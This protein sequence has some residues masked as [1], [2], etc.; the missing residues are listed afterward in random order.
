MAN[1]I[2]GVVGAGI[3][4]QGIVQVACL[5]PTVDKV[6]WKSAYSSDINKVKAKLAA[7]F[8]KLVEKDKFSDAQARD[9]LAKIYVSTD[10]KDFS[11][12]HIL[13][14]VVSEDIQI[15]AS[16]IS[17]LGKFLGK[18]VIIASNT[19]SLS[20]TELATFFS[21]PDRFI[22]MHF[23]NPAGL[24]QLVEI[25]SGVSTSEETKLF[26]SE[27]AN[28][29]D[30]V[31]VHVEE[32]PGFIVNRIL[33][34]MINEAIAILAESI[35]DRDSIDLAMKLGANHPIGPL[36]LS[37]LIGNDVVLSIL[38]VLYKETGDQKYRPHPLL[39]KMVRAKMLGKKTSTGFYNYNK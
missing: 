8:A 3:M 19:S 12:C 22:G 24:M 11:G 38:D 37:D 13:H 16:I 25:I 34:P 27:Y 39:K 17:E 20:I 21:N 10:Y 35:A 18:D 26:V 7:L 15:K 23:F 14:E 28:A 32:Y 31:S 5:A 30:K 9:A 36:A 2:V 6:I 33:I 29:L 4:G 1:I